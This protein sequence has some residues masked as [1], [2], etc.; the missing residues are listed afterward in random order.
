MECISYFASSFL[1]SAR[2]YILAN[3][4]SI[5]HTE[6]FPGVQKGKTRVKQKMLKYMTVAAKVMSPVSFS[7]SIV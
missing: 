7:S 3:T 4:G 6:D 1:V 2:K 5:L